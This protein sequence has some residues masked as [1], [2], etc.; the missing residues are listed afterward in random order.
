MRCDC[1]DRAGVENPNWKDLSYGPAATV[2]KGPTKSA[3]EAEAAEQVDRFLRR[4][5]CVAHTVG[6]LM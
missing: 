4:K 3:A 2:G 5:V 6:L 1:A